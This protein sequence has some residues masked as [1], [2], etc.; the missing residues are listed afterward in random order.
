MTTVRF[1]FPTDCKW[2]PI[3]GLEKKR[4]FCC[5]GCVFLESNYPTADGLKLEEERGSVKLVIAFLD[6]SSKVRGV[7]VMTIYETPTDQ[8]SGGVVTIKLIIAMAWNTE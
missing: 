1:V 5:C 4:R 3:T 2:D 6:E 8:G 7:S